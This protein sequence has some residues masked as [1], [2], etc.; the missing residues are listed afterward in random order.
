MPLLAT[1][2]LGAFLL[3][4]FPLRSLRLHRR[5]RVPVRRPRSLRRRPRAWVA[6]D[7]LFVLGFGSLLAGAAAEAATV[8]PALA[9]PPGWAHALGGASVLVST[10]LAVLGAGGHGGGVGGRH[11]APGEERSAGYRRA[12]IPG[13]GRLP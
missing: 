6:A 10:A 8:V 9:A 12:L 11:R 13:V 1:V 7:V 5:H 3:I 2:L 4:V